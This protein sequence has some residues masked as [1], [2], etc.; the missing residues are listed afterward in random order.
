[1]ILLFFLDWLVGYANAGAL[2]SVGY[3]AEMELCLEFRH[4]VFRV[5]GERQNGGLRPR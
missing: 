4:L 5:R 1:M 3:L 2:L